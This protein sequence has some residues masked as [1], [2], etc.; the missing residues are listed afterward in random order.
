MPKTTVKDQA[1]AEFAARNLDKGAELPGQPSEP[2]TPKPVSTSE[3]L[4]PDFTTD[5]REMITNRPVRPYEDKAKVLPVTETP[6]APIPAL[7]PPIATPTAPVYL[8][9]EELTGKMAKLKV[10]GVE[11]DV[12][13]ESLFKIKQLEQHSNALLQKLAEE[14]QKLEADKLAFQQRPITAPE[15]KVPPKEKKSSEVEALESRLADMQAQMQGLQATLIPQIQEAGIKRVEQM[16]KER[17]GT[18]DFRTYFDQIKQSALLESAKPEVAA[19]PRARAYFDSDAYYF[20]KYQELK[21]KDFVTK[22]VVPTQV[23]SVTPALVSHAGAPIVMNSQGQPVSMPTFESSSGV[24][25]KSSEQGDWQIR[26]Q[27]AFDHARQTGRTEDWMS[28][29]KLKSEAPN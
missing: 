15:E 26:S 4:F 28:Y 6:I 5:D 27:A 9:P 2:N 21:L 10:D 23:P 29:Y 3:K 1:T 25:S 17:I 12:P 18:E 13:A 14:R 22:P 11:Q 24:S 19:D 20:Q 7:T 8:K 16:V